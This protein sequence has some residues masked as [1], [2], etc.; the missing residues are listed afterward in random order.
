M[1]AA[2]SVDRARSIDHGDM[3]VIG[4]TAHNPQNK[5]RPHV[6]GQEWQQGAGC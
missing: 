6:S 5:N 2:A 1:P 3:A 4:K